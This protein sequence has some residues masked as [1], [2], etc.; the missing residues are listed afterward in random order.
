MKPMK[1]KD[2]SAR[3]E[4]SDEDEC[5]VGRVI[6]IND[7]VTFHGDSV[8]DVRKAFQESVDFY[9]ESCRE[10]GEEPNRTYSGKL[11]LRL[12]SEVHAAIARAAEADKQSINQ[13]AV[14]HL[15]K[16]GQS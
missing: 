4:Y 7:I 3:I 12:P 6:G 11:L 2:Y 10:R 16:A 8:D 1:Y 15:S 5:L 14:E 9:L 13:W